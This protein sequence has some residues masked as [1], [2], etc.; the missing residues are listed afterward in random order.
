MTILQKEE[1]VKK[2][3]E[4]GDAPDADYVEYEYED[5]FHAIPEMY[6]DPDERMSKSCTY[7]KLPLF[8]QKK[9]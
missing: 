4:K 1:S 9:K 3:N 7:I 6:S 2:L 8:V 5:S